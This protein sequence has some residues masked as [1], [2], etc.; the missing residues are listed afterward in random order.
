MMKGVFLMADDIS[1]SYGQDNAFE[2]LQ[3]L[4]SDLI[5]ELHAI[6]D[7][8]RHAQMTTY[9]PAR[10]L[11]QDIADDEK[12]HV[13]ELLA[14]IAKFDRRQAEELMRYLHKY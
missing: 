8:E 2:L 6:N 10:V 13:A 1:L 7:Y 14:M 9:G 11:F 4:R 3:M 12:H 5:G